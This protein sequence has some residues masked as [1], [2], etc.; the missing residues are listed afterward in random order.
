[1]MVGGGEGGEKGLESTNGE[2]RK[3]AWR[4]AMTDGQTDKQ[5]DRQKSFLIPSLE[6]HSHV[7]V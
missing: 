2:E 5:T 4:H 3:S 6:H 1:M 7:K